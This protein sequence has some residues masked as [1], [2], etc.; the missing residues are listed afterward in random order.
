[1]QRKIILDVDP[2]IDDAMAI[3]LAL[4]AADVEVVAVTATGGHVAPSLS[5]RN[6]QTIIEH[7]DPRRWPR[8]GAA[9]PQQVLKTDGRGI[10]G[11]NG[12]CGAEFRVAELHHQ[13]P[14][15]KVIC[16]EVRGAPG[17]VTIVA[18]G[19]LSN[20]A[21]AL[22]REPDLAS[23][24]GQ[25]II[26]GGAVSE[27]GNVTAAAEFNIYCDAEAAREVFRTPVTKSVVP[28]DVTRQIV[29]SYELLGRIGEDKSNS[30]TFL[31]QILPAAFRTY[32][33]R[34]GLEGIYVHD[35]V[36]LMAA[37]FPELFTTRRMHGDVETQGELTHGATVFDRRRL[38]DSQA[39]L[40]VAVDVDVAGVMARLEQL[41][42]QF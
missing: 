27:P 29:M 4:A 13:H 3:C 17:Q 34:L 36:A 12:F 28:I 31:N 15:D 10:H 9:N 40:D 5:T 41:M 1:M 35:V 26:S 2:G 19:P 20:V 25:I 33:Q 16:D 37:L 22:R 32:R 14:S 6:V 21:A 24:I 38:P 23:L 39:N 11:A 18:L 42:A 30:A 7:I 8:I